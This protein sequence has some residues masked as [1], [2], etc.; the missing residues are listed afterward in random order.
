MPTSIKEERI[1]KAPYNPSTRKER[2]MGTIRVSSTTCNLTLVMRVERSF[3]KARLLLASLFDWTLLE[4]NFSVS[5]S[6]SLQQVA[7]PR[8]MQIPWPGKCTEL[9]PLQN[10]ENHRFK[11]EGFFVIITILEKKM[12]VGRK[13]LPTSIEQERISKAEVLCIPSTKPS[14]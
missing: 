7:L 11:A 4:H 12:Y 5:T 3:S 14:Q 2:S 1:S 10:C 9:Y 13:I 6:S 8:E